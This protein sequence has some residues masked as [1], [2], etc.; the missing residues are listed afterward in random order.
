MYT[1]NYYETDES[2]APNGYD[3]IAMRKEER[4]PYYGN[5]AT[6]AFAPAPVNE[7]KSGGVEGLLSGLFGKL[8][9]GI[10]SLDKIGYEEILILGV[11]AFLLFS[12]DGDKECALLLL[13]LLLI[14]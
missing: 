7:P 8:H 3:G 6:E 9:I 4:E 5:E 12:A 14:N 2:T 10:P 1:R 11:A 13:L